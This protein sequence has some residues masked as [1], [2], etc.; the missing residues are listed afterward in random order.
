MRNRLSGLIE[1][2]L[3][4]S[5]VGFFAGMGP[6]ALITFPGILLFVLGLR[7]FQIT[8][9]RESLDEMKEDLQRL[10]QILL[11]P[12]GGM[13]PQRPSQGEPGQGRSA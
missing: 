10:E 8:L 9:A 12:R 2:I 4:G 6:Y 11:V 13:T 7:S 5:I 1:M 3:G